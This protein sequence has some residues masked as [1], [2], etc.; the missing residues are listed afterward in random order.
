[1]HVGLNKP[2]VLNLFRG[3][4]TEDEL[5]KASMGNSRIKTVVGGVVFNNLANCKVLQLS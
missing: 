5:V 2:G 1:M 4:R 3:F